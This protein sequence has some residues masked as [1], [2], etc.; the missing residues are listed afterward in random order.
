MIAVWI[1]A[2]S[3]HLAASF[4][5]KALEWVLTLAGALFGYALLQPADTFSLSPSWATI[6]VSAAYAGAS[7]EALGLSIVILALIRFA[8]LG[9]NGLWHASPRARGLMAGAY[10]LLWFM[11]FMGMWSAVGFASTGTG[12]YL[13]LTVGE[14]F[15][16][17]RT[18]HEWG[19]VRDARPKGRMH[20]SGN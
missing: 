18:Y 1:T 8:V 5:A 13:A 6:Q 12:I 17:I 19:E 15:N 16:V 7:E 20:D 14:V 10:A 9:Y 3:G 2:T 4:R 11:V